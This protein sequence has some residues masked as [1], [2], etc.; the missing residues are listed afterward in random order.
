MTAWIP[1]HVGD[2]GEWVLIV[3]NWLLIKFSARPN[4][5]SN[6]SKP[7]GSVMNMGRM[8]A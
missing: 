1:D 2:D 7:G 3:G 6:M 5:R 8:I 4:S